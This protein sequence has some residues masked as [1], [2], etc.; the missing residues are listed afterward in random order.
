MTPGSAVGISPVAL[1][2]PSGADIFGSNVST[3]LGPP[4]RNRKMTDLSVNGRVVEG[5]AES[6]FGSDSPPRAILPMRRK[7]RRPRRPPLS[8]MVNMM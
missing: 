2:M 1:R 4:C 3:W 8:P 7:S 6:N 5:A